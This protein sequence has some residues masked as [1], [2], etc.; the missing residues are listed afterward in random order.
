MSASRRTR[1]S[2]QHSRA[3][4]AEQDR[5]GARPRRDP[6]AGAFAALARDDRGRRVARR[7]IESRDHVANR[8]AAEVGRGPV[9][10]ATGSNQ[11]YSASG[12]DD[13]SSR[14]QL[15]SGMTNGLDAESRGE[16]RPAARRAAHGTPTGSRTT[17]IRRATSRRPAARRSSGDTD[18]GP[19][20]STASTAGRRSNRKPPSPLPSRSARSKRGDQR[21]RS[22]ALHGRS[23]HFR[24]G[25]VEQVPPPARRR[26]RRSPAATD[27]ASPDRRWCSAPHAGSG[28][29]SEARVPAPA[30]TIAFHHCR[31]S[32]VPSRSVGDVA[33]SAAAAPSYHH[34]NIAPYLPVLRIDCARRP[35]HRRRSRAPRR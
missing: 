31:R 22:V 18:P 17:R 32:R 19:S 28:D 4:P 9:H 14:N 12:R 26:A 34:E 29:P 11:S 21:P 6:P 13:G 10:V 25:V 24:G 3:L 16:P 27:P 7:A 35:G 2:H 23:Q 33:A 30:R 15:S 8:D 20:R 1:R 5:R